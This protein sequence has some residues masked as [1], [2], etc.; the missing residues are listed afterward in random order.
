MG[1]SNDNAEEVLKINK[2]KNEVCGIKI[3]MGSSTGNMLVD[4]YNTLEKIFS[5]SEMLIAT[6]CEDETIIR[7]NYN[8]IKLIK[9]LIQLFQQKI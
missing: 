5:E 4:N 6:H 8:Q 9:W 2:F 3:F 1:V 7:N